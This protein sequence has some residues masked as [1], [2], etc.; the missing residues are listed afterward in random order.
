MN[1]IIFLPYRQYAPQTKIT[2]IFLCSRR[3]TSVPFVP[4]LLLTIH[5]YFHRSSS[6]QSPIH[7]PSLY[8]KQSLLPSACCPTNP[9]APIVSYH[10]CSTKP[11]YTDWHPIRFG[12]VPPSQQPRRVVSSEAI[13]PLRLMPRF[14]IFISRSLAGQST[15]F[16]T[17]NLISSLRT[18][19]HPCSS[20]PETTRDSACKHWQ[21]SNSHALLIC[22]IQL[23]HITFWARIISPNQ[24]PLLNELRRIAAHNRPW[25]NILHHSH[26]LKAAIA[27]IR[28]PKPT[29]PVHI[30]QCPFNIYIIGLI[31]KHFI[32]QVPI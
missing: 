19:N 16:S 32:R 31:K 24:H 28:T 2:V 25:F 23:S 7:Q 13:F 9:V 15:G 10:F 5:R 17:G 11:P 22:Y 3:Q 12:D 29:M 6:S 4:L 21:L 14:S 8:N 26:W 30:C 18:I 27:I 20:T 1:Y